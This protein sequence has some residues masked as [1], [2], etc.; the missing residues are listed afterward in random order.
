MAKLLAFTEFNY[1]DPS[2]CLNNNSFPNSFS[3]VHWL[4]DSITERFQH[5][6]SNILLPNTANTSQT[7]LNLECY[8]SSSK[9]MEANND[10]V[11]FLPNAHCALLF[12]QLRVLPVHW[13]VFNE[14]FFC[15]HCTPSKSVRSIYSAALLWFVYDGCVQWRSFSVHTIDWRKRKRIL[16]CFVS[17]ASMVCLQTQNLI[18]TWI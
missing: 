8:C 12:W 17:V 3:A 16:L 9:I 4:L 1:H 15:C 5:L 7:L 14:Y 18:S 13:I 11:W 10:L 6:S 2:K